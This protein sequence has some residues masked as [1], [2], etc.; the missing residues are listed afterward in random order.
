M[1]TSCGGITGW[2]RI[3]HLD[4]T[5][6][7]AECPSSLELYIINKT[8]TCRI[9]NSTGPVCSSDAYSSNGVLY[10]AVCGRVKGYQFNSTDAFNRSGNTKILDEPYL[11]GVSITHGRPRQHVWSFT[12]ALY[13]ELPPPP[14]ATTSSHTCPCSS[15]FVGTPPPS[16]VGVDYFCDTG[17]ESY[18]LPGVPSP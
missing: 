3:T 12:A 8:K 16:Y 2:M 15:A 4:M 13:E 17:A 5:Q 9:N 1:I 7:G 14:G 6:D 10:T 18:S 11:D